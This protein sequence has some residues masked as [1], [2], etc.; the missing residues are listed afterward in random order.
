MSIVSPA[1]NGIHENPLPAPGATPDR[2]TS[3]RTEGLTSPRTEGLASPRTEGLTS[4]RI[5][6]V[7]ILP[8]IKHKTLD[9]PSPQHESLSQVR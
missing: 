2:L 5:T 8:A 9:L 6:G 1:T 3:P 7:G 4:P